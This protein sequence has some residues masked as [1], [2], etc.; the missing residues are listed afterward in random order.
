[1]CIS[2]SVKRFWLAFIEDIIVAFQSFQ[3]IDKLNSLYIG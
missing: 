1:M 3:S 2:E